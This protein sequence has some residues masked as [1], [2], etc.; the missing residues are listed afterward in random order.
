MPT[1]SLEHAADADALVMSWTPVT[2]RRHRPAQALPGDRSLRHRRR[3]DRPGRGDRTRH[4][5]L[6][7]GDLLPR[8]SQQPRHGAVADAESRPAAGYR[9]GARRG[10]VA[11][12][13][14]RRRAGCTGSGWGW[15][16]WATSASWS[17]ARRAGSGW[18][19]WRTIPICGAST[20]QLMER[21]WSI[22]TSCL[23]DRRH[24]QR[25]LSA[26]R[27]DAPPAWRARAGADEAERV[28]DQHVARGRS[29]IRRR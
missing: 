22:W 2:A 14:Q 13:G 21:R 16:G 9:R 18:T 5:G 19:W 8:R 11:D 27:L 10:L 6:Q 4:P 17:P 26:E 3:H 20:P 12:D 29:S 24:C 7:H 1:A 23:A 15:S 28:F 25:A